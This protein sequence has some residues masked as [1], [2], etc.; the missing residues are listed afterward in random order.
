[1]PF[2][3]RDSKEGANLASCER[4][5]QSLGTTPLS[6]ILQCSRSKETK[7]NV[8]EIA[9]YFCNNHFVV[10][11]LKRISGAKLLLPQDVRWNSVLDCFEEELAMTWVSSNHPSTNTNLNKLQNYGEPFK[12]YMFADYV[13]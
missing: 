2:C 13:L 12:K 1:M 11:T 9:K 6:Q 3:R 7:T 4:E 5:F 10:P 8:A